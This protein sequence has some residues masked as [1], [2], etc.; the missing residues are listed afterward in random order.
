MAKRRQ[1]SNSRSK[2][3]KKKSISAGLASRNS[4]K[5]TTLIKWCLFFLI[6]LTAMFISKEIGFIDFVKEKWE[7]IEPVATIINWFVGLLTIL[8]FKSIFKE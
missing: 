3:K 7:I 8:I 5:L 4:E 1:S 6:L 2:A